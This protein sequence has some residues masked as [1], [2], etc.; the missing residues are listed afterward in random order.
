MPVYLLFLGT[1]TGQDGPLFQ[2][3]GHLDVQLV[4]E[5]RD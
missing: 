2:Q 1:E 4:T 3:R 5:L